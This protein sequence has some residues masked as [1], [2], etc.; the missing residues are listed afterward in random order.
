MYKGYILPLGL[1]FSTKPPL[2]SQE[3]PWRNMPCTNAPS[4]AA[5]SYLERRGRRREEEKE[6]GEEMGE[7][8]G[9]FDVNY[10]RHGVITHC[11]IGL[12]IS[13][14]HCTLYTVHCTHRMYTL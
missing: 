1:D 3:A 8:G 11:F 7:R 12:S 14:L 2:V 6:E 10:V 9:E 13:L 4:R 5:A